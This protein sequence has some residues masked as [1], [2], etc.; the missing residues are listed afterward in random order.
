MLFMDRSAFKGP[1]FTAA[2]YLEEDEVTDP[3]G[4]RESFQIEILVILQEDCRIFSF[5][6]RN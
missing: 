5:A 3:I 2:V 6:C 4:Y 1:L